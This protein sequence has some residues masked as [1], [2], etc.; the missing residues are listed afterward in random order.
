LAF[1]SVSEAED[2]DVTNALLGVVDVP[3]G[4]VDSV[5]KTEGC[6]DSKDLVSGFGGLAGVGT[7]ADLHRRQEISGETISGRRWSSCQGVGCG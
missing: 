5:F 7:V 4:R 1:T 6:P 2:Q 3:E